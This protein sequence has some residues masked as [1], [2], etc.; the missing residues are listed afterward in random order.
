MGGGMPEDEYDS[1]VWPILSLLRSGAD[2]GV[3]L[4]RLRQIESGWFAAAADDAR[5]VPAI[6][7][8]QA[9]GIGNAG[10]TRT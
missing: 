5:F 7:R 6:E 2:K 8:L 10:E 9:A 4:R 1:Y 3:L